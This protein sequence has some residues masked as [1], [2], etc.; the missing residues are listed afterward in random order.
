MVRCRNI[1]VF[2]TVFAVFL[3]AAV[4]AQ[5][6]FLSPGD[7]AADHDFLD[8]VA[9]CLTC[10]TVGESITNDKCLSCHKTIESRINQGQGFHAH[11]KKRVCSDCHADHRGRSFSMID[12]DGP[13]QAFR[14]QVTGY[15]L[16]GKHQ[17]VKCER[18][19]DP[20]L[21]KDNLVVRLL[22]KHRSKKTFL[23]LGD[24]CSDC[25]FDE[26]RWAVCG[27]LRWV[28]R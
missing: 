10:H 6:R 14:H 25:H 21:I 13:Q 28:S 26:H 17:R 11:S 19:H 2:C 5:S 9:N 16:R 8:G 3:S 27:I 12:W 4:H 15:L 20:R 18:R 23:G 1:A 7:L 22:D 24:Q